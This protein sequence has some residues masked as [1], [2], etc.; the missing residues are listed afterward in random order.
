MN[1]R[2]M[3]IADRIPEGIGFIDVGTDHGYLPVYMAQN[4]Y[5]G[6]I[7]ASDIN[8]GPLSAAE[9]TAM[10]AGVYER[11]EFLLC[12]G[13]KL[14]DYNRVDTIVIAG[15]GGDM[16]CHILDNAEWC[17]DSRY[18]LILQPMTKAEVLRYWL[19]NNGFS[20]TAENL[21]SD[22]GFLYQ[23]IDTR[24]GGKTEL[25]DAELFV[26]RYELSCDKELYRK[27]LDAI[28]RRIEKAAAN[29]EQSRN[30]DSSFRLR[31]YR[32]ILSQLEMIRRSY[33]EGI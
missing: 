27:Q 23:I 33:D 20:I 6:N 29:M 31:L 2:L 4:G 16:I 28:F 13:L 9:R 30:V 7:I 19:V 32:D 17:M 1:K 15:M 11:L 18:K 24:F 3:T 12:D 14:C 26:G 8:A 25:N 10:D 5:T 21:V 22:S